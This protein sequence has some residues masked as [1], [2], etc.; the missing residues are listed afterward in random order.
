M[1]RKTAPIDEV[2]A[3]I[4]VT[5]LSSDLSSAE[6][7]RIGRK[8]RDAHP[9]FTRDGQYAHDV[10]VNANRIYALAEGVARAE[11]SRRRMKR[12]GLLK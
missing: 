11:K 7:R 3:A 5:P 1:P 4:L 2:V 8:Y 10:Y 9:G 6:L 12:Q